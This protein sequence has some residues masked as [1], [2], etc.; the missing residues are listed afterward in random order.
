[1]RKKFGPDG[2]DVLKYL[3]IFGH[4]TGDN[5]QKTPAWIRERGRPNG[6]DKDAM[7]SDGSEAEQ[8]GTTR[9]LLEQLV[10]QKYLIELR[11]A[12]FQTWTDTWRAAE[13]VVKASG[14]LSLAKG[15]KGQEELESTVRNEMDRI[16]YGDIASSDAYTNGK[17]AAADDS[18]LPGPKR[19]K[20]ASGDQSNGVIAAEQLTEFHVCRH[21]QFSIRSTDKD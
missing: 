2:A 21:T 17:R 16:L 10:E 14:S 3:L 19:R 11:P 5:L 1:M 12:H 13:L 6:L 7:D 15:K 20:K 9:R 8:S 18:V 4:D